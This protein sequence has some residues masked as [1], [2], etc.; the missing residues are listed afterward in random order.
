M[1]PA[2]AAKI[3]VGAIEIATKVGAYIIKVKGAKEERLRLLNGVR[4]CEDVLRRFVDELNDI[5]SDPEW[6]ER[7][8][9]INHNKTPMEPLHVALKMAENELKSTSLVSQFKW[10]FKEESVTNILNIIEREKSLLSLSMIADSRHLQQEI[11]SSLEGT[12]AQLASLAQMVAGANQEVKKLLQGLTDSLQQRQEPQVGEG[13]KLSWLSRIDYSSQQ[14]SLTRQREGRG[15]W[16]LRTKEFTS[17]VGEKSQIMFC[18]GNPGAG[19]TFLTSLVVES[20]Q[21]QFRK[22]TSVGI[23]YVYC[24][25]RQQNRTVEDLFSNILKQLAENQDPLP[26]FIQSLQHDKSQASANGLRRTF[27]VVDAIDECRADDGSQAKLSS[28]LIKL[29]TESGANVFTTS[30]SIPAILS[31]FKGSIKFPI[32]AGNEDVIDFLEANYYRI[33]V[34]FEKIDIQKEIETAILKSIDGMFLLAK[35]HVDSLAGTITEKTLRNILEALP[36]AKDGYANAYEN[37][38]DRIKKQPGEQGRRGIQALAWIICAKRPLLDTELPHALAIESGSRKLY[39]TNFLN[40]E[41]I[42]SACVGLVV[43]EQP[44]GIVSLIHN[45]AREYLTL[46]LPDWHPTAELLL[47][48]ARLTYLLYDQF[49]TSTGGLKAASHNL[50]SGDPLCNDVQGTKY[51]ELG[52]RTASHPLYEYAAENWGHHARSAGNCFEVWKTRQDGLHQVEQQIE[53]ILR[54][55]GRI[56]DVS[57]IIIE[58]EDA[59]IWRRN[60]DPDAVSGLHLAAY[61]GLTKSMV[62]FLDNESVD[63]NISESDDWTPLRWAAESGQEAAA[64]LLIARGADISAADNRRWTAIHKAAAAKKSLTGDGPAVLS[65]LLKSKAEIDQPGRKKVTTLHMAAGRG[66]IWL[67]ELLLDNEANIEAQEMHGF[68]PLF[69]AVGN[70]KVEVADFLLARGANLTAKDE[71]GRSL[72]HRAAKHGSLEA[73]QWLLEHERGADINARSDLGHTPLHMTTL[74]TP[75]LRINFPFRWFGFSLWT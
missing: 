55:K 27:I 23:A 72:L 26:E 70:G 45:T 31:T 37:A 67:A 9:V 59:P 5:E 10:P 52:N 44:S 62:R 7:I 51:K 56:W 22:D 63:L 35:L 66:D 36:S 12:H 33:P 75:R 73:A 34:A 60:G 17:W 49:R 18:H 61:F 21:K 53:I 69:M 32:R 13:S 57:C 48:E 11:Q 42:V 43:V 68:T 8:N 28:Q 46:T 16:L 4:G 58:R 50:T 24:S 1:D 74:N 20:L 15:Q 25:F 40:I 3:A 29:R 64:K 19:K 65:L 14:A 71:M 2:T 47:A 38:V 54:E 30:R 41:D 39:L 6:L